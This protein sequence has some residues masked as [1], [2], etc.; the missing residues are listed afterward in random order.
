M[1]SPNYVFIGWLK[2]GQS[3]KVWGIIELAKPSSQF[4]L[5]KYLTFWGRR[6]SKYQTKVV[7][8]G[9]PTPP[10]YSWRGNE[11]DK[12]I[13]EKIEKGYRL[14]RKSELEKVYPEFEKDLQQTTFWT[15]MTKS[16]EVGSVDWDKI[17]KKE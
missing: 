7:D 5:G 12:K 1:T 8:S 6:G 16:A 15:M 3:D 10:F 17:M 11:L 14:V 9:K 13:S 2:E 4:A